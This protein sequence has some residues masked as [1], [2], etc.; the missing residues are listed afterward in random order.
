MLVSRFSYIE[1]HAMMLVISKLLP[2]VLPASTW[3][4][5]SVLAW[6]AFEIVEMHPKILMKP[7]PNRG[8]NVEGQ[9]GVE[10]SVICSRPTP[11]IELHGAHVHSLK[12]GKL[13][14]AAI[15]STEGPQSGGEVWTWGCGKSGKLGQGNSDAVHN[16]SR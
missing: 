14:S 5:A 9:C 4:L 15:V 11:V 7:T 16:P 10:S 13:N 8:R 1:V 12:A 3:R 2:R 6:Y